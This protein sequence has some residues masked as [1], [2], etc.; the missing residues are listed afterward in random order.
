[1]ETYLKALSINWQKFCVQPH[2]L[3]KR[4]LSIKYR[5]LTTTCI[6]YFR[7]LQI[8]MVFFL[9]N[10][11]HFASI[12]GKNALIRDSS[13]YSV[14]IYQLCTN[15]WVNSR[16]TNRTFGYYTN[17]TVSSVSLYLSLNHYFPESVLIRACFDNF[18]Q[19]LSNSATNFFK[20]TGELSINCCQ[21][22]NEWSWMFLEKPSSVFPRKAKRNSLLRLR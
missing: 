7:C 2:Y 19:Q 21:L 1:M 15:F 18:Q 20:Y 8:W 22:I 13:N 12:T 3:S 9:F 6:F 16:K 14:H 11:C 4:S 5:N 17:L 10:Q